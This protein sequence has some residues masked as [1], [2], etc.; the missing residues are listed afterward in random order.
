MGFRTARARV[1]GLGTGHGG[2]HHWWQQR[3]SSV[4]LIPLTLLFVV[5][6]ARA[7]GAGHAHVVA[8]YANPFHALVAVLFLAV[9]FW[10][11]AQGLQVV[12]EDYVQHKGWRAGLVMANLMFCAVFGL[13]GIFAVAKIALAG[14]ALA[15]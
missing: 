7:L 14:I 13:A 6:F 11:L 9:G 4:A 3:L 15:G 1:H 10:H 5:P 12:I 2:T 8:L